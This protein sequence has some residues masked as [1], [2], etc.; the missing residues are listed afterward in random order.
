MSPTTAHLSSPER[1]IERS[2]Q[3]AETMR[4]LCRMHSLPDHEPERARLREEVI[5][6]HMAYARHIARRYARNEQTTGEDLEQVAYL[7]LVK[8]VDGFDPEFGTGFLGYATALIIGEIKRHYRDTTWAVHVPRRMQE[9][10]QDL[11]HANNALT[12]ELGC[13]PTITQLAERL[14]ATDEEIVEALDAST[15][16]RTASL[17]RPVGSEQDG[18]TMG[19]LIGREDPGYELAVDRHVLRGLIAGLDERDKRILL[20][21]FFRGMTQAEIGAELG[22][23][24]MQISRLIT[25]V[26]AQLRSGFG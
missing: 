13:P 12:A 15:A 22:V 19:E 21:R 1:P 23:S 14:G 17:D 4:V 2:A 11:R 7:G 10:S 3:R 5:T 6:D 8:A 26:L 20:M 25:K 16:Y 18:A 24:Q 9:L